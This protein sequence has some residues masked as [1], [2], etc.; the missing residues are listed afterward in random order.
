MDQSLRPL[1]LTTPQYAALSA[2]E[3]EAGI[4]NASLAR[5]A[6]VTPQTM[7][8]ILA[9]LERDGLINREADPLHGRILRSLL[10]QRGRGLLGRAHQI[11]E[12]LEDVMVNLVGPIE[13]ERISATLVDWAE[14][15]NMT[16]IPEEDLT[17]VVLESVE[18]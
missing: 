10:T 4:S 13:A 8:G 17:A 9:N 14:A 18:Q 16:S 2:I 12:E 3:L 6:F 5:A 15:L 11:V 1:G 7:Q